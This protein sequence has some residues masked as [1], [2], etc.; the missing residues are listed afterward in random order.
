MSTKQKG[1]SR[2]Q[3]L[4]LLLAAATLRARDP[5]VILSHGMGVETAAIWKMWVEHPETRPFKS[6]D[7]LIVVTAQVGEEVRKSITLMETYQLPEIAQRQVRFVELARRGHLEEDGIVVLQD[8]R[9]PKQLHPEGVYR[10]TDEL[11]HAGTVPQY[12]GEHRCALKFKAW[13]I[14]TWLAWALR[15]VDAVHVFGY[16]N[17]ELSRITQ[18]EH[19]IGRH[20]D[21]KL[22]ATPPKPPIMVFGFNNEELGRAERS[23]AYDGPHRMG[24]YPL[25]EFGHDRRWCLKFLQE[26]YGIIW[27][28]SA[29]AGCPFNEEAYNQTQMGIDRFQEHPDQVAHWLMV[30]YVSMC[31]NP[32]G[33]LYQ[34]TSMRDVVYSNRIRLSGV[35]EAFEQALAAKTWALYDVRRIITCNHE[36]KGNKARLTGGKDPKPFF[37]RAVQVLATGTRAEMDGAWMQ[38]T[39]EPGYSIERRDGIERA[40]HARKDM[41]QLPTCEGYLVVAPFF[42]RDKVS[43][44]MEVFKRRFHAIRVGGRDLDQAAQPK[45]VALPVLKEDYFGV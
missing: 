2:D 12:A 30:E 19:H 9:E 14:E 34:K 13:V 28:K 39:R 3:L 18:S 15:G 20:N 38:R 27:I 36:S 29:C 6:W 41:T 37:A 11:L 42:V 40:Y 23:M 26:Q 43:G 25:L 8:T 31:L 44:P 45:T 35:V 16:N 10:L 17:A 21:D 22:V 4:A 5:L 33:Q 1:K 32:A 7:R 24:H